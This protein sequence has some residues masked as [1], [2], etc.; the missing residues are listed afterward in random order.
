[1]KRPIPML[2]AV[3]IAAA[4][5]ASPAWS[6][7]GAASPGA[8]AVTA[9]P[10][11]TAAPSVTSPPGTRDAAAAGAGAAAGTLSSAD[12]TF[13]DQAA[14]SGVAT[15]QA[16]R[17]AVQ[18]ARD[19]RVRQFAQRMIDDHDTAND[20]LAKLAS[21]RGVA[22]PGEPALRHREE[23]DAL[24]QH[25]GVDFDRAYMK[26]QVADHQKAV[27]LFD[28]QARMG[29][30]TALRQWAAKMLPALRE[31]LQMARAD[32]GDRADARGAARR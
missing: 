28:R 12:R 27:A 21:S 3:A 8:G 20:E 5:G 13:V 18:K 6:Q 32:A 7:D 15:V 10:S 4:L 17:L 29:Q 24:R 26:G 14:E 16:G 9:P 30:D 1:M 19:P 22:L 31:H 11:V 25:S 23:L 2:P